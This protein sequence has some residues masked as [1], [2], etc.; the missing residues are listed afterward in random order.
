MRS[1]NYVLAAALVSGVSGTAR[2]QSTPP[3]SPA[4]VL[5]PA[6]DAGYGKSHWTASGFA[7]STFDAASDDPRIGSHASVDFGGQIG[8][9]WKSGVGA[10]F[11][12]DFS[13]SLKSHS[14]LVPDR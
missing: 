3:P 2:A 1:V 6:N 11:L 14:G 10:E 7:G 9:L 8:Y 12:S 13:P 5:A 4:P